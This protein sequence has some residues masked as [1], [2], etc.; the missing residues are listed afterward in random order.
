MSCN[1]MSLSI[2]RLNSELRRWIGAE[3]PVYK[4]TSNKDRENLL[5]DRESDLNN[6]LMLRQPPSPSPSPTPKL[7][8][9][10]KL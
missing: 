6:Q 5:L 3:K 8:R 9:K 2:Y 10:V 4:N 1:E 7:R